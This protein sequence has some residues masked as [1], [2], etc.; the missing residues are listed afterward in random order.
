M[1]ALKTRSRPATVA[2]RQ[3]LAEAA[4]GALSS[5]SATSPLPVRRMP[6]VGLKSSVRAPAALLLQT[7]A[8]HSARRPTSNGFDHGVGHHSGIYAKLLGL[9]IRHISCYGV[10]SIRV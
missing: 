2:S 8:S 3:R 10:L 4:R 6:T 7:D 5:S 9:K 1:Y